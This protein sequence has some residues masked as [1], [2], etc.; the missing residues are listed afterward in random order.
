MATST[1]S[2]GRQ[3][4][5]RLL[6][7][8]ELL[9]RDRGGR[10][11]VLAARSAA[12]AAPARRPRRRRSA[13]EAA[14]DVAEDVLGREGSPSAPEVDQRKLRTPPAGV[15]AAAGRA[16]EALEALEVRLAVG[17]DL[18]AVELSALLLV[19]D[20][21]VG[22]VDLGEALLGLRVVLVLVGVRFLGELAE[23]RFDLGLACRLAHAEHFVGIAHG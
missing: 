5:A 6:A 16:A 20:D 23:G 8:D 17:A 21:L 7:A 12:G 2:P 3:I 19:A 18:A 4:D 11:D 1:V 13:G 9:E 22:G 10:G 14:E 15:L